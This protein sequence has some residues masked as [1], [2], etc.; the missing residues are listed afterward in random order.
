MN[1]KLLPAIVA[2]GILMALAGYLLTGKVL[3][4][5]LI[6]LAAFS[7]TANLQIIRLFHIDIRGEIAYL[8][9]LIQQLHW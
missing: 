9:Y 6:I 2:F 8:T 1:K 5:V 4:M 3:A 7:S